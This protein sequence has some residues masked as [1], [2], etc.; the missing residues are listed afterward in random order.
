MTSIRGLGVCHPHV[1]FCGWIIVADSLGGVVSDS[2]PMYM[3]KSGFYRRC[4][5]FN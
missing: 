4:G 1:G 5:V 2:A 3:G